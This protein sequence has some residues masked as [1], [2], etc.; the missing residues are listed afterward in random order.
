MSTKYENFEANDGTGAI[1]YGTSWQ[2]Q[3]FAAN[4]SHVVSSIK[5]YSG[6]SGSPGDVTVSL[7]AVDANGKPTGSDLASKT[8]A[9]ADISGTGASPVWNEFILD[10]Q[11]NVVSG[12]QYTIVVR[13]PDGSVNNSFVWIGYSSSGYADGKKTYSDDSGVTWATPSETHDLDFQIWG[14]EYLPTDK[15]YSKKLVAAANNELWY[16]SSAGI[17]TEL[18]DA[19]SDIDT[20]A[21][22]SL[23]E[24]FGKIFVANKTNLK[25]TDFVNT[26]IIDTNGF[27]NKP[28]N[29]D[30]VYQNGSDAA[31]M[32]V[33][34][35][36]SANNV[37]YGRVISGT[38][39]VTTAITTASGGGGNTILPSPDSVTSNPHW[40]DWTP[41]DND[42][43]TYG[44]LPAKA[45]LGCNYRGRAVLSGNVDYPHQ[46]Y[47]SRQANPWDFSYTA[48]DAQ[49]PVVGGNSD[50]GEIGDIIVALIPYKDDFLIFGCAT[51]MWFLAGDP[52]EGGSLNEL[53]LT[54]GIFGANSWCFDG[55]GNLYFWG[56]N[57]I[58]IT[59]IPGIPKCIS[60]V[61]LPDLIGD[62]AVDSSTHRITMQYDRRRK[63]ICIFI[64]KLSDGSNSNYW[65]DLRTGGFFPESYPDECGVFS[66]Y[67]YHAV[68]PTYR[69]LILGCNDGYLR[70]FDAAAKDDDKGATDQA[71]NSYVTFGPMPLGDGMNRKGKF[72]APNLIT[73]GGGAGGSQSDSDD[74]DFKMF[75][76][77]SAERVIEKLSANT[78]P[79]MGGTFNAPGRQPGAKKGQKI[80]GAYLGLRLENTASTE[81]WGFEKLTGVVI[82]SGRIR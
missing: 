54:V 10:S 47:M 75:T 79:Q 30:V 2:A 16:E 12:T 80:K 44:A 23:F 82:P 3:T 65:Y 72:L 58:Y 52:M 77:N 37:M 17:M 11:Y 18:T 53:D 35:I 9:Q 32:I 60:D 78:N 68:D 31:Q 56:T 22:L 59:Q 27:T 81:T 50:A 61:R 5:L 36:D 55:E 4:S 26:K 28:A 34:Y 8:L 42:T 33:D 40:Y 15:T 71:I 49:S 6:L 57:G 70:F 64:T 20:T 67:F 24:L 43:S 45:T 1:F 63:G 7:R 74:V 51:S 29:G 25:V 19:N 41:Y 14:S 48:N 73:A 13:A 76:A 69:K 66:A 62:E 46:W 21:P 39:E 38:F